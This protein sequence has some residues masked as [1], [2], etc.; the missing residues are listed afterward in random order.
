VRTT[1]NRNIVIVVIAA[2]VA[3]I[4][5]GV[6][7][8][9]IVKNNQPDQSAEIEETAPLTDAERFKQEYESLNDTVR[10]SDG[11]TYNNVE[12]SEDNPIVYIDI[13]E[14]LDLLKSDQAI[15]YVG[16]NWCPHCRNSVPVLLDVAKQ[17]EL[18]KV[19]YLELDDT[20][21]QYEWQDGQAVKTK[22]GTEEY[23]ALLGVL[24]DRLN[25]YT[26]KDEAGNAQ[27]TGE[28]RIYMPYVLAVKDGQVVGDF[29]G[30]VSDEDLEEGQTK[31]DPLT[32]AQYTK[33][34]DNYS[35][36]F[37]AV[38]GETASDDCGDV[39]D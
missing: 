5:L 36:L 29:V 39:C 11:A 22:D 38:Y 18:D 32:D 28:K 35:N 2:V 23:Y 6:G 9:F 20:K 19:Y 15:I 10:E 25:D 3:A 24:A 31:Y 13:K 1:K 12:I 21:S 30:D 8:F 16:A 33:L 4:L 26:I 17:F 27:P 37:K 34:F 14:A 7:I